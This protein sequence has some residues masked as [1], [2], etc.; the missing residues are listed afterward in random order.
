[1]NPTIETA[2]GAL[3]ELPA[4]TNGADSVEVLA[5]DGAGETREGLVVK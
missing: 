4:I 3:P 5:I 1:M 2:A